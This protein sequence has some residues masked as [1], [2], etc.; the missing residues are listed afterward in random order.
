MFRNKTTIIAFTT[1]IIIASDA[2][3]GLGVVI[4]NPIIN[5]NAQAPGVIPQ[6][7]NIYKQDIVT[8]FKTMVSSIN[9]CIPGTCSYVQYGNSGIS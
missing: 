7:F 4:I 1:A 2:I 5:A 6:Q 8:T 9:P 3:M